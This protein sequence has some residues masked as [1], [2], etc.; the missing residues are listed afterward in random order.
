MK[1]RITA[2]LLMLTLLMG[3]L[4]AR[5]QEDARTA[6]IDGIIALAQENSMALMT[7][8]ATCGTKL[9]VTATGPQA[10]EV[11]D[12]LEALVQRKFDIPDEQ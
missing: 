9:V 1:K 11:L 8:E 3:A 2:A 12:E 5:A 10:R 7:L 4:P 6:L